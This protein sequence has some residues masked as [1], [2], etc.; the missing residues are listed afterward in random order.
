MSRAT[1]VRVV[2]VTAPF[3]AR[4]IEKMIEHFSPRLESTVIVPAFPYTERSR[5]VPIKQRFVRQITG[6]V[7]FNKAILDLAPDLIYSDSTLHGASVKLFSIA[8]RRSIPFIIHLRGDWWREYYS[9]FGSASCRR[10][11]LSSQQYFYNWFSLLTASKVTPICRWL[12]RVV[13]THLPTKPTEVVYQ[14]V[15]PSEFMGSS[16]DLGFRKPAVAIIQNHSIYPKVEG[17]LGFC[18]VIRH[19]P[20]VNFYIAEGEES[21]QTY[22]PLVKE[23]LAS[24]NTHFV[25]GITTPDAVRKML[26]SADVY[27]L[28]SGLDC[29]PTTVLEASLMRRPVLASRVGGVPETVVENRT[30][31]TIPNGSMIQWVK[32]MTSLFEDEGLRDRF[33]MAGRKWVSENF[34]W[35]VIAKHVEELIL[36][37]VE[38]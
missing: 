10:R 9:W 2:F 35:P 33:G 37:E 22:L 28:A 31:W 16:E 36:N 17:L 12:Q 29:C 23:K 20:D 4:M 5:S 26:T 18:D 6:D 15:D 25:K 14:G 1:L 3:K 27:I 19:L 11:L 38:S 34:A 8:K 30:G 7:L 13:E 24:S 21:G 32:R